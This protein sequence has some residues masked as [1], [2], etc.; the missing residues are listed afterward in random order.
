M[1]WPCCAVR[2]ARRRTRACCQLA[3][4]GKCPLLGNH[5]QAQRYLLKANKSIKYQEKETTP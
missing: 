4:R 3:M 2:E 1:K 5:A